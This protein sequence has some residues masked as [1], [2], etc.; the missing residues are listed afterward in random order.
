MALQASLQRE[1]WIQSTRQAIRS[2]LQCCV[3]CFHT[4]RRSFQPKMARLPKYSAQKVKPLE[5]SGVIYVNPVTL[6]ETRKQH[7]VGSSAYICLFVC[8]TTKAIHLELSSDLSTETFLL[9][10]TRFSAR[11]RPIKKNTQ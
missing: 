7:S 5:I 3:P 10:F 6:K 9:A 8:T 2:P 1:F 4:R 11:C